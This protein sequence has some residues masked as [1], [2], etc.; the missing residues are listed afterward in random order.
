MKKI[1]AYFLIFYFCLFGSLS[2]LNVSAKEQENSTTSELYAQSAVLMDARTGR[3]L[4]EKN[5][6]EVRSMASTT[7]IMTC[8][9]A[10]ELGGIE[11]KAGVSA[12]AASMPKVHIGVTKGEYYKIED[13]LYA[14]MLESYNDAAA[15]VAEYY[16]S[17]MLNDGGDITEH[18]REESTRAI[19]AFTQRMNEKAEE[20]GCQ[21]TYFVTPNGLDAALKTTGEDG[22]TIE[23]VHSSTAEDMA[24]I[25][26]YCVEKSPEK[27]AFL[28]VTQ[29]QSY[30]FSSWKRE[31]EDFKEGGRIVS[32]NNHNA[33]LNMIEG[34]LSGKTG[35][36]NKAGYCYVG[37]LQ[38]DEKVFT[39]ALLACGW[40]NN[41]TWKWHDTK[42][43]MEY[44]L[45]N[46]EWK[47][48]FTK[49]DLP[50]LPVENG[51]EETTRIDMEE[52]QLGLLWSDQD[53]LDIQIET[54]DVLQAPVWKGQKV[55]EVHYLVNG[56]EFA[57]IPLCAGQSIPKMTY[58]YRLKQ[59]LYA[60]GL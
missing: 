41:K 60:F 51:I 10:L 4:L 49:P 18:S 57:S 58:I 48:I 39:V 42:L 59:I 53:E 33:F 22:K 36:T 56:K 45:E 27:E 14:L 21:N 20:I 26:A 52:E 47:D 43:L 32:C 15:V 28:K 55:G 9:V 44:G 37:A 31:G 8:I 17:K 34:A 25:M 24:R 2:V 38:K 13:L 16:G 1:F 29:T 6:S 3:I 46:Y 19:L 23:K 12:Y 7:K 5:G 54:E 50:D 40:P 30:S 35:F 11:E